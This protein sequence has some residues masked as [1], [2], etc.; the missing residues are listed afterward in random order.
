MGFGA[1]RQNTNLLGQD[2]DESL[3]HGPLDQMTHI[4]LLE[5]N[6]N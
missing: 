4:K 1:L 3:D 2:F 6:I 5:V